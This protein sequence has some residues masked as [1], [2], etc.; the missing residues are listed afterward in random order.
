MNKDQLRAP[1]FLGHLVEACS[2]ILSYTA[3]MPYDAYL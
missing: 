3:G 2:R 1:D